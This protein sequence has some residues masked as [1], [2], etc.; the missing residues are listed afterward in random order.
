VL[1]GVTADGSRSF[2]YPQP[3]ELTIR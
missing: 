2:T 1:F 3:V